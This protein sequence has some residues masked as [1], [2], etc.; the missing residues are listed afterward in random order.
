[1]Q[2][3]EQM[4]MSRDVLTSMANSALGVQTA[5]APAR[6][7]LWANRA[8]RVAWSVAWLLLFRPSP[9]PFHAWRRMLLRAFGAKIGP[10]AH[11][12]PSAKIWAP[13]NLELGAH[14]CLGPHVDC[15]SVDRIKLG[16]FATVSQYSYLCTATHDDSDLR[17]PLVTAPI[18]IGARA[19]VCADVFV[20]PGV[21]VGDGSVVGARSSVFKSVPEWIVVAGTPAKFLRK[22]EIRS[23]AST[24]PANTA[25]ASGRPGVDA[26]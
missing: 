1:M 18:R 10:G 21:V 9:R 23:G 26:A 22:R 20:G 13:W 4:P 17:L 7:N 19:W 8:L 15:Y 24:T 6:A 2:A 11:P 25:Q 5:A 12:Y 14:S 3:M 16:E